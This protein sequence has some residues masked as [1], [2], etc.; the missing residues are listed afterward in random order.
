[1]TSGAESWSCE[2]TLRILYDRSGNSLGTSTLET[3]G[4]PITDKNTVETWLRR[5]QAAILCPHIPTE[6]FLT[7]TEAELRRLT[8]TDKEMLSFSKN[9]VHVD[10]KDPELAD[11]SFVDLPGTQEMECSFQS[12]FIS[13]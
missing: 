4:P 9:V 3:F 1:M 8:K 6:Q 13:K 2:I 7:K 10:V 5:A 12:W 11:L